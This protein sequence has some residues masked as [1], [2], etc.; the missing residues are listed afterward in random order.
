[1]NSRFREHGIGYQL[2]S[3]NIVRVDS[4]LV[5]SEVVKPAFYLLSHQRFAGANDEFLK[6]HEHYR[7]GR[8]SETINE[9]LKAFESVLKIICTAKGWPYRAGDT[10][11]TLLDVV[12]ERGLLPSF[13]QGEFSGLRSV[14]ESSVPTTRNKTSA[15]GQGA[16]RKEVPPLFG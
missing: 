2:E 7:H 10:A 14:L 11:Q 13:L 5:H 3:G 15:H 16:E 9:C 1:L 8:A 6:A 12:F 4:Q